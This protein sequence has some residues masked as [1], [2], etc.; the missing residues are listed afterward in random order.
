M[1]NVFL[2]AYFIQVGPLEKNVNAFTYD[3][4]IMDRIGVNSKFGLQRYIIYLG[5]SIRHIS[6]SVHLSPCSVTR[7]APQWKRYA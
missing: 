2:I 7:R 1:I 3:M 6:A 5:S 4:I